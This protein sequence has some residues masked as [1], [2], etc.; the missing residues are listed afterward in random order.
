VNVVEVG[1]LDELYK[2]KLW[3]YL[4]QVQ[5][6]AAQPQLEQ[7]QEAFPQPPIVDDV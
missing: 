4:P 3:T 7:E 2:I 5:L 6:P 1:H